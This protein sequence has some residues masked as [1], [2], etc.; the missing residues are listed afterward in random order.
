MMTKQE[1]EDL[2]IVLNYLWRDEQKHY[3]EKPAK[4]HIYSV[5]R[6]LAKRIEYRLD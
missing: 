4:N 6:R 5:I 3:Q 2:K 1:K